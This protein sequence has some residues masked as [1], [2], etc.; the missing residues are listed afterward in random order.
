MQ[1]RTHA[2]KYFLSLERPSPKRMKATL[3]PMEP[4]CTEQAGVKSP[5]VI[6]RAVLRK[7]PITTN[8]VPKQASAEAHKYCW[9]IEDNL[10]CGFDYAATGSED[11]LVSNFSMDPEDALLTAE[12]LPAFLDQ[13]F[14]EGGE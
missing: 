5:G 10:L 3:A 14:D 8:L 13:W 2:Q 12:D 4:I 6:P 7:S 11:D 1:V 9:P